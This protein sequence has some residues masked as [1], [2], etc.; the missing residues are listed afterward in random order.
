MQLTPVE[1]PSS[2]SIHAT[3]D[4]AYTDERV[5]VYSTPIY[6]DTSPHD[7]GSSVPSKRKRTLSPDAPAKRSCTTEN[8]SADSSAD[9][10]YDTDPEAWRKLMISQMFPFEAPGVCTSTRKAARKERRLRDSYDLVG[11][12][13]PDALKPGLHSPQEDYSIIRARRARRLPSFSHD[14]RGTP[15]LCYVLIGPTGRGKFDVKKAE[16]LGVPRGPVRGQLTKGVTVTFTV[17]DGHGN[18]VERTVK[19]ED[20]VGPP[21]TPRVKVLRTV[22]QVLH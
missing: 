3:Y 5:T 12:P 9:A 4:P 21:E 13:L 7:A 18:K 10:I 16:A 1:V 22:F 15:T 17:D 20:V 14:P 8:T 2:V 6:P 11:M 19:P